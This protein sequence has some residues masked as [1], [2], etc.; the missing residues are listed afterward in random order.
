MGKI[1]AGTAALILIAAFIVRC[2][3]G[4]RAESVPAGSNSELA[5][6]M[7]DLEALSKEIA[8]SIEQEK[9]L[10]PFAASFEHLAKM[11]ATEGMI[12]DRE[13]FSLYAQ[14]YLESVDDLYN[15]KSD[16]RVLYNLTVQQ[17]LNCHSQYCQGPIK[18]I[19]KLFIPE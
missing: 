15:S 1:C 12:S 4:G 2:G 5:L 14:A 18:A 3:G 13:N 10:P 19:N 8:K 6:A 9:A 17:C 16:Q 11:E 7:R